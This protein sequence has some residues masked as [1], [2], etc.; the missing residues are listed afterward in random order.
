[1]VFSRSPWSIRTSLGRWLFDFNNGHVA[2]MY[3]FV[4]NL[5]IY[6]IQCDNTHTH[7]HTHIYWILYIYIYIYKIQVNL[8]TEAEGDLKTP[9]WK[10]ITPRWRGGHYSF[11][12]TA[13]LYPWYGPNLLGLL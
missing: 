7:T 4:F 6:K 12:S 5:I 2:L 11:P 8:A 9:F 3:L 13:T 1:M 10:A